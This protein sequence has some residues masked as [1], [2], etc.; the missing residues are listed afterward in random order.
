MPRLTLFV[1]PLPAHLGIALLGLC[2][3]VCEP[4]SAADLP[5]LDDSVPTSAGETESKLRYSW[6]PDAQ[7]V[8]DFTIKI[9]IAADT[10]KF[11]GRNKLN[12]SN[13]K[14]SITAPTTE[15]QLASG[16]GFVVHPEGIIVTCAHVVRGATTLNAKIGDDEYEATL[17]GVDYDQDIAVL[18]VRGKD[19][20]HV[21][22]ADS[23]KVRLADEVRALGFPLTKVLGESIKV[24]RGEVSGIGGGINKQS[25]LQ[26]D[27]SLNPG[28]SG[29]PII[30]TS[31]RVVGI[32]SSLLSGA[33]L[34]EV[35]FA[36]PSNVVVSF[37]K[38]LHVPVAES[39]ASNPQSP[40]DIVAR[41]SS[42][43]VLIEAT[44]GPNG[45][46]TGD[47]SELEY[48]AYWYNATPPRLGARSYGRSLPEDGRGKIVLNESG[49][50]LDG[51]AEPALPCLLGGGGLVGIEKLSSTAPGTTRATNQLILQRVEAS[52]ATDRFS[53]Y[54]WRPRYRSR[55]GSPWLRD[56][57]PRV[58][59]ELLTGLESTEYTL[60]P[61]KGDLVE[62]TKVYE[63]QIDGATKDDQPYLQLTGKGTGYFNQA[64]G[65]MQSIDYQ[66]QL[67][68]TKDNISVRVP[69]QMQY[70]MVTAEQL[71]EERR[72]IEERKK[73]REALATQQKQAGG[74]G[75]TFSEAAPAQN[76]T[77]GRHASVKS[78]PASPKLNKFNFDK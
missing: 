57:E 11:Q 18:R 24:T 53:P 78:I 14:P 65:L 21:T 20:P 5:P 13:R 54:D 4:A 49:E 55:L 66:G 37:L 32:A 59:V 22:F 56:P 52:R 7:V 51:G 34:S 28:N 1:T 58:N 70:E 10:L 76:T 47:L 2:L 43:C 73:Q 63:L 41:L 60:G 44:Y 27:A 68:V 35:G 40:V 29:G 61:S 50:I 45:I 3:V 77:G 9:D 31:G 62:L 48:S 36:I 16:S 38:S 69:L 72:R 30:D 6:K 33:R 26:L 75:P 8:Y 74:G 42:A 17:I 64:T 19:L 23:E 71:A 67:V 25:G 39:A 46:G 15:G 12:A